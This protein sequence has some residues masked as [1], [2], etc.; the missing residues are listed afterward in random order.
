MNLSK[1]LAVGKPKKITEFSEWEALSEVSPKDRPWDTHRAFSD[2]VQGVLYRSDETDF[3]KQALRI[4]KCAQS[5][6]F[7]WNANQETGE[8]RLK[9][10]TTFFCRVKSCSVCQWR[11]SL[12]W[13][14]RFYQALP[15]V[16]KEHPTGRWLFL[17]LTVKNCAVD[18]LREQVKAM[19]EAFHR[20]VK[21]K[22]FADCLGWV[23]SFEVT[24]GE[25]GSAHPHFHVLML[26]RPSYFKG[27]NYVSTGRWV[28]A[29]K[30]AM[31]LD[32]S[33]ICH[34]KAVKVLRDA[35]KEKF[36]EDAALAKAVAETLKYTVKSVEAVKDKDWFLAMLRQLHRMRALATGGVLKN[37][38][39]L[40]DESQQ[41]LLLGDEAGTV[42]EEP[43]AKVRFDWHHTKSQYRRKKQA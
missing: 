25:D 7:G 5:L 29:W 38:F 32:Y 17:T 24:R 31:R 22:E 1:N 6:F 20:L 40:E 28:E 26:V 23:R 42:E 16:R 9:L 14:A 43:E 4:S 8:C 30:G 27:T 13:K 21:R 3:K 19:N 12:M 37:A 10:K 18:D 39:R 2:D 36:G 41:D 11:R 15:S 34:V 35:D 33:P